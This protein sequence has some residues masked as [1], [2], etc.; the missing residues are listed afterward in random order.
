MKT[1][2][3]EK[4]TLDH[5]LK[6][7]DAVINDEFVN[8][9]N[10]LSDSIREYYKVSKNISKNKTFLVN[11]IEND[12]S[13]SES[14]LF[15]EDNITINKSQSI[16]NITENIKNNLS[17][18]KL[19]VNSGDKNLMRFFEDA[20]VIFKKMK[21]KRKLLL[22]NRMKKQRSSHGFHDAH[23]D[24]D[25]TPDVYRKINSTPIHQSKMRNSQL[26]NKVNNLEDTDE[27]NKIN[28]TVRNKEANKNFELFKSK[29]IV[30]NDVSNRINMTLENKDIKHILNNRK[31]LS[32]MERLKNL[33][34]KY[35]LSI[36]SLKIELKKYQ[37]ELENMKHSSS[38]NIIKYSSFDDIESEKSQLKQSE[39]LLNK[40]KMIS[41]LK[42][43]IEKNNIKFA[44]LSHSYMNC[45]L[46]IKKL[47]EE[48][49]RLMNS[50]KSGNNYSERL[51]ELIK[52][53]NH[54]KN[55]IEI[56]KNDITIAKYPQSDINIKINPKDLDPNG[57]DL[58]KDIDNLKKKISI[59]EKKLSDEKQRNQELQSE[60]INLKNKHEIE[61]S[62]L[63]KK[64][65]ELNK[66]LMDK[67][68][69]L[70][71]LQKESLYKT[72]EIENLK[73]SMNSKIKSIDDQEKKKLLES[74]KSYFEQEGSFSRPWSKL[75][76]SLNRILENYKNENKLLR[77]NYHEKIKYY[78]DQ[79]KNAKNEIYENFLKM[80]DLKNKNEKEINDIKNDYDKKI[81]EVNHK[82][83]IIDHYLNL[84]QE[85][86]NNLMNRICQI[87]QKVSAKEM[88][89][90]QLQE[91]NQ[92]L[93]EKI[94]KLYN[95]KEN[96]DSKDKNIDLKLKEENKELSEK[97][98]EQNQANEKLKEELKRITNE[99][100]LYQ[101]R[102]LSLGIK[103]MG[104]HELQT[105]RDE[106]FERLHEEIEQLKGQ[107]E[108][109]QGMVET[110][111]KDF[112]TQLEQKTEIIE[113]YD[114][115]VDLKKQYGEIEEPK[116]MT[117][118]MINE[119]DND[120]DQDSIKKENE[121][122]TMQI[123]KISNDYKELQIKY[124]ILN[125]KNKVLLKNE[126]KNM[127]NSSNYTNSITTISNNEIELK[128]VKEENEEIKK[129]NMALISQL[130]EKEINGTYYD[131]KSEDG[132]KS[133]Y[134]EEF[135]LKKMAKGARDKN[136]SQDINIDYPGIQALK[137]KYRELDF[138]YNSL[139][140][141]VKKLLLT[142]QVNQKNRAYVKELCKLVGFD[143]ETTN[144]I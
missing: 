56:L 40:D 18:L 80:T 103:F 90:I 12:V 102:L 74:I 88:K 118:K 9:I 142:I 113:N 84:C 28:Y 138:N 89:I 16:A 82:N 79:L 139:E 87:N 73:M 31:V 76:E 42:I 114:N 62:E 85:A 21:D 50:L 144:K 7:D 41:S 83:E 71:N 132:K 69:E 17:K 43:D 120:D 109:L 52:E 125:D 127:L 107:N 133:N 116:E 115:E 39:L 2:V 57:T 55:S 97:L 77:T 20:K 124:N 63:S 129:K 8:Y 60:S 45:Q 92:Q 58:K 65:T 49:N 126:N 33:N 98:D 23:K 75:N 15:N 78:Q 64:N 99:H 95:I 112:L 136:R 46:E 72:K 32:E 101:Q 3:K 105:T 128:K 51:N 48:N 134:E 121:Q 86:N 54:L 30:A 68:N 130:E 19:N 36:K 61:L 81:E 93:K 6:L 108:N 104:V 22:Q 110:L 34:K 117:F 96:I 37:S 94:E 44:E 26:N 25:L 27:P 131:V 24:K 14:I 140:G 143:F 70:L 35:E 119:K 141:L 111:T 91:D 122:L 4:N 123:M 1:G 38:V 5:N 59:I 135:D 137:E 10:T 100:D 29:T 47:Q 66:N 67:Q 106:A 13:I 53:N 11:S